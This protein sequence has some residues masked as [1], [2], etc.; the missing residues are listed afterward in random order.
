MGKKK[1]GKKHHLLMQ[2]LRKLRSDLSGKSYHYV[3][4]V[5]CACFSW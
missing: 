1:R 5:L 2:V 3:Q 4:F